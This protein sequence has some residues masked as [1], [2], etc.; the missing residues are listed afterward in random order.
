MALAS[1]DFD[2]LDDQIKNLRTDSKAWRNTGTTSMSDF[3]NIMSEKYEYLFSKSI[4][5]FDKAISGELES[6]DAESRMKHML[7][8]LRVAQNGARSKESV[9]SQFGKEMFDK[10]V[11]PVLDNIDDGGPANF[12]MD[13]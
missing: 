8:L 4:G 7:D 10:H 2:I 3:H 11:Q 9:E 1:L 5:L 13:K 12:N 6:E